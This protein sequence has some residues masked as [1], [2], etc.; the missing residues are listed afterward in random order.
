MIRESITF[1]FSKSILIDHQKHKIHVDDHRYFLSP[2]NY[3]LIT[4]CT[5]GS[6]QSHVC[7]SLSLN[8]SA[9]CTMRSLFSTMSLYLKWPCIQYNKKKGWIQ[10]HISGEI[11]DLEFENHKNVKKCILR[12][13]WQAGTNEC[14]MGICSNDGEVA[15]PIILYKSPKPSS[16][17]RKG[18]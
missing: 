14:S 10:E 2:C 11:T 15:H 5:W 8:S 3:L 17:I 18:Q 12:R 13:L 1:P 6:T 16:H 9:H 7:V 4:Q